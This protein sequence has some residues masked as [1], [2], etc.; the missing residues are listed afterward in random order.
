MGNCIINLWPLA[1][2]LL[3]KNSLKL[4]LRVGCLQGARP[5]RPTSSVE[6]ASTRWEGSQNHFPLTDF[7][8]DLCSN[9]RDKVFC[10]W[11]Q[12]KFA[13][14]P[15]ALFSH[16]NPFIFKSTTVNTTRVLESLLLSVATWS[17]ALKVHLSGACPQTSH[18]GTPIYILSVCKMTLL[19]FPAIASNL[20]ASSKPSWCLKVSEYRSMRQKS[21]RKSSEDRLLSWSTMWSCRC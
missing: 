7:L 3:V 11:L 6:V 9:R 17:E 12:L 16:I 8:S 1:W 5:M 21:K 14:L 10:T 20:T 4:L 13:I 18:D 2:P 15:E 19:N